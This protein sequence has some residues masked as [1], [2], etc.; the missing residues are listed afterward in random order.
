MDK[1]GL[2]NTQTRTHLKC[3]GSHANSASE[4]IIAQSMSSPCYVV[5]GM[6]SAQ[7]GQQNEIQHRQSMH[8]IKTRILRHDTPIFKKGTFSTFP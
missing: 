3:I 5:L 6:A 7:P 4:L 1:V 8:K 2:R